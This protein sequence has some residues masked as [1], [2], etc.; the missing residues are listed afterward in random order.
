MDA[1]MDGEALDEH[2]LASVDISLAIKKIR[3]IEENQDN[4]SRI[5]YFL[6]IEGFLNK[7]TTWANNG[8]VLVTKQ[9]P[10]KLT[11]D[12]DPP[13]P[14][15]KE[16]HVRGDEEKLPLFV[17]SD[18]NTIKVSNGNASPFVTID[19]S[20]GGILS[21][22]WD[23]KPILAGGVTPNFLRAATDN[24]KGGI[25]L[26]LEF[27]LMT[28]ATPIFQLLFGDSGFSYE[29]NWR[30]CGLSQDSPPKVVCNS[31]R[32]LEKLDDLVK[33][34]ASIYIQSKKTKKTIL[35]QVSTYEIYRNGRISIANKVIPIGRTS[36]IPRIGLSFRLNPAFHNIQYFGRGPNENYPDRKSGSHFG[37]WKTSASDMGYSYIVPSENGSRSDCKRICFESRRDGGLAVVADSDSAFSCSALLHS[38][39][40]LHHASH[41]CDLDKRMDGENL[42]HVNIDHQLMGVGGDNSWSPCV[43]PDFV[44]KSQEYNYKLWFV[45]IPP[46]ENH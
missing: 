32:V 6:N 11:F 33:I 16:V 46:G 13:S 4:F 1:L 27:L 31:I 41:T 21:I 39:D 23:G 7:D 42:I 29:L 44:V 34:E 19:K 45:K 10:L 12:V 25:E 2:G 38:A 40:E 22:D 17:S 15:R 37:W 30:R 14:I 35:E 43:Y 36:S 8:H 3:F 5:T 9:V 28:W 20:N 18:E 24:D 26:V